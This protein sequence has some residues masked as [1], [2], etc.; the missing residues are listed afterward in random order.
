MC[1]IAQC[2]SASSDGTIKIWDIGQQVTNIPD[3]DSDV[4][5]QLTFTMI[6]CGRYY[7]ILLPTLF[8]Q[9]EEMVRST[10][11]RYKPLKAVWLAL[12]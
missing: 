9:E 12:N 10:R 6:R 7:W 2:Y 8:Y 4:F 3:H 11:R 1:L 5:R